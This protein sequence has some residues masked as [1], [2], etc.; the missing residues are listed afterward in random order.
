MSGPVF[1]SIR[2]RRAH[3]SYTEEPVSREALEH[4][5]AAARWAPSASNRRIQRFVVIQDPPT[6]RLLGHASPGMAEQPAALI[7][8]CND[9]RAARRLGVQFER[10][11]TSW[12]DVGAAAQNMMLAAHE[13]GL[14]T[15]PAT[16]FSRAA[17]REVLRL[18]SHLRPEY[19]LQ[20]G[21]PAPEPER[22]PPPGGQR[23]RVG[24]LA[25]WWEP[26]LERWPD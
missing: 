5:L 12:I 8:I 3:R 13:M 15:C 24:R 20:I 16:S 7:L 25:T 22:A 2:T 17:V 23:M 10:D 14:A 4:L 19:F 26:G 11:T 6:I 21:H 18:P 9:Q 1:E